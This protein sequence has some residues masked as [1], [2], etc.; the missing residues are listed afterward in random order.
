MTEPT[1]KNIKNY[2]SVSDQNKKLVNHNKILEENIL[3]VIDVLE[4]IKDIDKRSLK[5]AKT[6]IQQGFMWLNRSIFEPNRV[7]N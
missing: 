6:N 1:E 4:T 7:D 5:I 2:N 3:K